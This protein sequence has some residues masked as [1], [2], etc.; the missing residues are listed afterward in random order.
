MGKTKDYRDFMT[1]VK[2][3]E[4]AFEE[5]SGRGLP[6]R[7]FVSAGTLAI[8]WL[9]VAVFLW[10][11]TVFFAGYELLNRAGLWLVVLIFAL[12]ALIASANGVQYLR[13]SRER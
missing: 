10:G 13:K 12:A 7:F 11:C 1:E 4:K 9:A 2:T 8:L 6:R 3:Q 5:P